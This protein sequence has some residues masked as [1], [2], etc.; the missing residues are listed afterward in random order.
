MRSKPALLI[1]RAMVH[2]PISFAHDARSLCF[3]AGLGTT[4]VST[5]LKLPRKP[6]GVRWFTLRHFFS[7]GRQREIAD[8]REIPLS[9]LFIKPRA[10]D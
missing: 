10:S 5:S 2:S 4:G 1:C 7:P 3:S 6:L 9:A 8:D